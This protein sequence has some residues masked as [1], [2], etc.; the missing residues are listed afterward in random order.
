VAEEWAE[1]GGTLGK[2]TV[3]TH[4]LATRKEIENVRAKRRLAGGEHQAASHLTEGKQRQMG[5]SLA[6]DAF[7]RGRIERGHGTGSTRRK[8]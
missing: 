5:K 8:R 2:T 4:G 6:G 7:N 1:D 3:K